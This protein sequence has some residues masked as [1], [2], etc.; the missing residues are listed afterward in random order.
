M[1]GADWT[2][3][4]EGEEIFTSRLKIRRSYRE[5]WARLGIYAMPSIS[6]AGIFGSM[7]ILLLFFYYVFL[8]VFIPTLGPTRLRVDI[9]KVRC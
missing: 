1:A 3:D 5:D 6:V 9:N 8:D 2:Q 7:Q 4:H